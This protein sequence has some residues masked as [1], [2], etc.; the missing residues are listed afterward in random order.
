MN[1]PGRPPLDA[2]DSTV[3]VNIKMPSKQLIDLCARAH[4]ERRTLPDLLRAL[5]RPGPADEK[6]NLK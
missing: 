5:L 3:Q 6:R 4:R 2:A 1:K